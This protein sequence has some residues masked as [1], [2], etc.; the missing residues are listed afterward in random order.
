MGESISPD[1]RGWRIRGLRLGNTREW[2]RVINRY[3]ANNPH[4]TLALL[5]SDLSDETLIEIHDR[6]LEIKSVKIGTK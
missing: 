3:R 5:A 2:E 1:I 6:M 4:L